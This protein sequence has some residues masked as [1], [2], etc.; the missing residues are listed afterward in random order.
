MHAPCPSPWRSA[1]LAMPASAEAHVTLQPA[2]GAGRRV[3]APRRTRPQRARRRR[4][5]Q[6]RRPAAAG[7]RSRPPTS[8]CR[9]D[10]SRSPSR[11]WPSRSRSRARRQRAG[12]ADHLDRRRQAGRDPARP[13]PGL[14]PLAGDARG[15]S[16]AQAH[17]Q[18][19]ADLPGRRGR[20]LDRPGG[21]RRARPDRDAHRRRRGRRPRRP[22][23][24]SGSAAPAAP[25]SAAGARR[26]RRLRRPRHRGARARRARPARRPRRR[27]SSP[28]APGAPPTSEQPTQRRCTMPRRRL[29]PPSWRRLPRLALP[30][31]GART[32]ASSRYSPK[33]GS[34]VS[35][36]CR[37]C[38][39]R[40][41]RAS[42]TGSCPS[43]APARR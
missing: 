7:L 24:A 4:H 34:R 8:R 39:S 3:H 5:D 33:P 11:S 21:R 20:A 25:A 29:S 36:R 41:R 19:A 17:L 37:P 27:C 31:T 12:R 22:A 10:R 15:R 2:D 9:L 16:P 6:G 28:A 18:G 32:P 30:A 43:G 42:P 35:R 14:R 38:A 1:P 23:T 26:R 40:S 13:V